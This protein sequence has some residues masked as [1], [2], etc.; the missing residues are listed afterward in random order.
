MATVFPGEKDARLILTEAFDSGLTGVK[1]HCHMQCFDMLGAG[2]HD[3][4]RFCQSGDRPLTMHVGREPK[5][6]AYP[7]N[8]YK[9][10]STE[11]LEQVIQRY[12]D[13]KVCVP[14][15]GVEN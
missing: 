9:L 13:L 5:S 4:H 10:C 15:L 7:C 14:H 3:I 1:L 8:S 2:M 11:K 6:P 12:P